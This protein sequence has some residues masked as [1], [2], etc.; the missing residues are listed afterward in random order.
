MSDEVEQHVEQQVEVAEAIAF[1]T[2]ARSPLEFRAAQTVDVQ[3][4]KR[5]VTI[6]AAPYETETYV[7]TADGRFVLESIA[8]G[9]WDGVERRANR[10]KVNRDHDT[11]RT[12][13]RAV[14]LHPSRA[15]GLVAELRI[16]QTPLGDESL[17]LAE[18]RVLDAS[19]G[20]APFPG[21][22]L[23]NRDRSARSIAKAFL[24]HI[25]L[26]PDPAYETAN[27]LDVRNSGGTTGLVVAGT[28]ILDRLLAE[29]LAERHH[30]SL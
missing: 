22:E 13:G 30:L 3:P 7:R 11:S 10:V 25:A 2:A 8:R 16:A 6:V 15:E 26:V 1:E 27:V 9:A 20:F 18:D 14:A 24:G 28:P 5:I 19:V 12:V 23:W 21:F 4:S 29:R 17:A